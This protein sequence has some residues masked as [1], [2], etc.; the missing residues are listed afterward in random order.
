MVQGLDSNGFQMFIDLVVDPSEDQNEVSL[1]CDREL[2][3]LEKFRGRT[4]AVWVFKVWDANSNRIIG[5]SFTPRMQ[6][7]AP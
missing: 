7:P 6:V 5:L 2:Y 4:M 1:A 3:L